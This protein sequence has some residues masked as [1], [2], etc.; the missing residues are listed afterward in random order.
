MDWQRE[1]LRKAIRDRNQKMSA[2]SKAIRRNHAYISQFLENQTPK[3]LSEKDRVGVEKFLSLPD[4][5]LR[6]PQSPL[7]AKTPSETK[8]KPSNEVLTPVTQ[9]GHNEKDVTEEAMDALTIGVQRLLDK[10]GF[11]A[12]ANKLEELEA[13]RRAHPQD[14]RRA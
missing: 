7:S 9:S 12:V 6:N 10:Y 2:V 3:E 4:S 8:A 13:N 1:R 14:R 5:W 11:D